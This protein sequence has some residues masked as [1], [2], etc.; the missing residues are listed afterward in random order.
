MSTSLGQPPSVCDMPVVVYSAR[1]VLASCS[2][3]SYAACTPPMCT[4]IP[5]FEQILS[6]PATM[7]C[8]SMKMHLRRT[9]WT[10]REGQRVHLHG[11]AVSWALHMLL[12]IVL[13]WPQV[14]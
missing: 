13:I 7:L 4:R 11:N 6:V 5:T 1:Y 12:R 10:C 14:E 8:Q 2:D 9:C 3:M